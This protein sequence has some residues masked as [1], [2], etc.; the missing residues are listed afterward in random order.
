MIPD[1][2]ENMP[3]P[4]LFVFIKYIIEKLDFLPSREDLE[5]YNYS[6]NYAIYEILSVF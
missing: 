6:N 2:G 3:K 1:K 4:K 5:L